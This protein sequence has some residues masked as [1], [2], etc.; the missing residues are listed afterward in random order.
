[1]E[2]WSAWVDGREISYT[3]V[4]SVWY[5]L[6]WPALAI[7]FLIGMLAWWIWR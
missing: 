4:R 1:M 3:Q 7:G 2:R 6:I 5:G